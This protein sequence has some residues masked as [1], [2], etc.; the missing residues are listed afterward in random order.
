[1]A[2]YYGDT[3]DGY[4]YI[5]RDYLQ[6]IWDFFGEN[7][8]KHPIS[9]LI[10]IFLR[11]D[12]TTHMLKTSVESM[13]IKHKL[14]TVRFL[15]LLSRFT[16]Y[17]FMEVYKGKHFKGYTEIYI[18]CRHNELIDFDGDEMFLDLPLMS[19]RQARREPDYHKWRTACLKRD[20]FQC[21]HCGST[22]NLHVHHIK[23]YA[24][25]PKLATVVSNGITLCQGCHVKEHRR[26]R[27]G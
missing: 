1:M 8:S 11:A 26:M 7:D 17:G 21:Q 13:S 27:N 14:T 19:F 16:D 6:K 2:D 22:E 18:A 23:P 10:E 5:S 4:V 15:K 25:Y 12:E 9:I 20:H 24:K 3:G